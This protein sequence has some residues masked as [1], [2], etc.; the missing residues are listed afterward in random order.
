MSKR[1]PIVLSCA[2][3]LSGAVSSAC[4]P[5]SVTQPPQIADAAPPAEPAPPAPPPPPPPK[6]PTDAFAIGTFNLDWA[7]DAADVPRTV[8]G[9]ENRAKTE[10]DWAWK[11]DGIAELLA[12]ERLDVVGLQ[13][14]GGERELADIAW[15][16]DQKGGPKYDWVFVPSDDKA[17]G[18]H[19]GLLSRF[20]IANERRL[21]V[22]MRKQ[23]AADVELPSGDTITVVVVHARSGHYPAYLADRRK[24][25]R[26]VK[27]AL[28]QIARKQP[29]VVLGTFH[30]LYTP[31]FAEYAGS[32]VGIFAGAAT[33][34]HEDD[35]QDSTA[36]VGE[37]TVT[38]MPTH[39]VFSCGLWMRAATASGRAL[40]VRGPVDPPDARWTDVPIATDPQRDLGENLVVWAEIEL[41]K[42][43][44]AE[45]TPEGG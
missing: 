36:H 38:D 30:D 12:K 31:S 24:Q 21:D 19:V 45:P 27:R 6:V 4:A 10:D 28:V 1:R 41:P 5:K 14:L 11:R 9:K 15:A 2:L 3:T 25:A 42:K 44:P 7:I 18:L 43:A 40:V 32:S 39:R 26:S 33:K 23:M 16:I 22:N 13:E 34:P 37:T 17:T 8:L 35:C 20:P 29:V